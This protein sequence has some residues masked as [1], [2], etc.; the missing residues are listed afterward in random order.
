MDPK[1]KKKKLDVGRRL[2]ESVSLNKSIWINA[3][4]RIRVGK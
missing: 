4:S 3:P 1:K 2:G